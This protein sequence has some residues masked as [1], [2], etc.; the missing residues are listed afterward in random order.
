MAGED[1]SKNPGSTFGYWQD[2]KNMTRDGTQLTA[3]EEERWNQSSAPGGDTV[4]WY[5][6]PHMG[7][8]YR[9]NQVD[10]TAG[11]SS[12]INDAGE[13][14]HYDSPKQIAAD[15]EWTNLQRPLRFGEKAWANG[16]DLYNLEGGRYDRETNPYVY[17]D[18]MKAE[19]RRRAAEYEA[20]YTYD[21]VTDTTTRGG[22]G[23][24]TQKGAPM[25]KPISDYT[26]EQLQY[27][28]HDRYYQGHEQLT[29]SGRKM[30]DEALGR[31]SNAFGDVYGQDMNSLL[32]AFNDDSY[33]PFYGALNQA[34]TDRNRE[35]GLLGDKQTA[36]ERRSD[37]NIM[38]YLYREF[39]DIDQV[40]NRAEVQRR[41]ADYKEEMN[42]KDDHYYNRRMDERTFN[43][44]GLNEFKDFN[45]E[46]NP[47]S[48]MGANP[49]TA[50]LL[51]GEAEV[52]QGGFLDTY[53]KRRNE[54]KPSV[55]SLMKEV[56]EYDE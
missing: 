22:P 7:W 16:A 26:P 21:P 29:A 42:L 5:Y 38:D 35:L 56:E 17:T 54:E 14:V 43:R 10:G 2:L 31:R 47:R 9:G 41:W 49:M 27:L 28:N 18:E 19:D 53:L 39:S 36:Y 32:D 52:K 12:Y 3:T 30:V 51:G 45:A 20:S 33:N 4:N 55:M 1:R 8:Q 6:V 48:S 23:G 40:K 37:N 46:F 25:S 13:R 44:L 11:K 15:E 50:G 34:T 24:F